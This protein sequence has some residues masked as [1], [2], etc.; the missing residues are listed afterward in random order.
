MLVNWLLEPFFEVRARRYRF[1]ILNASVSRFMKFALV[2]KFDDATSGSIPG[3]VGSDTSYER[4]PFWLIA[5]CGNIMM[6]AIKFDGTNG[7]TS[8]TLPVQAIA[9][10]FDI[11]VDFGDFEEGDRLYFVNVLEHFN[12]KRPNK[13]IALEPILNGTY[14]GDP[15]VMKFMEFRVKSYDGTDLSMD[16]SDYEVGKRLMIPIEPLK[17]IDIR[18]AKQRHFNF[19]LKSGTSDEWAIETDGGP[20]FQADP[21]RLSAAPTTNALE[22]WTISNSAP[23]WSHNVHIHYTEGKIMLRD[24]QLPPIWEQFARKDVYRV[25]GVVDS[26]ES[27]LVA[28][29]F[30]DITND[31]LVCHC[32]NTQH[33]DHAMLLRFDVMGESCTKTLPC[34]LP[35][36]EG[37]KFMET[38]TLPTFRTGLTEDNM[39]YENP[40]KT[41]K[42]LKQI[43]NVVPDIATGSYFVNGLGKSLQ[44][45]EDQ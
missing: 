27:V 19:T 20:D 6:H 41:I 21:R 29:T 43:D 17:E 8:A 7:T 36:W 3:P 13:E 28:L 15:C 38:K 9:E 5:N 10:R 24:G 32:H 25:G 44:L 22:L 12:G 16:P 26:S 2:K 4:V 33:E 40:A 35:T 1:R 31:N 18:N 39:F 30:N 37:V 34:P 11:I 14:S 45:S 42:K 23:T